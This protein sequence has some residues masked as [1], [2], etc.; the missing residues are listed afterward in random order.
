MSMANINTLANLGVVNGIRTRMEYFYT[1]VQILL[2]LDTFLQQF[3]LHLLLVVNIRSVAQT[4]G[5]F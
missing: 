2:L 5:E 1:A 3:Q 4:D